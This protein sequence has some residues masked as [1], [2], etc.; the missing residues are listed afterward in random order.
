MN[1][2]KKSRLIKRGIKLIKVGRVLCIV[3]IILAILFMMKVIMSREENANISSFEFAKSKIMCSVYLMLFST[4][5]FH[6]LNAVL[7]Y[8]RGI[9][10][11]N[12]KRLYVS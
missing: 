11:S 8:L 9:R 4:L 1:S 10:T 3:F 12:H 7:K 5:L 2:E 6:G